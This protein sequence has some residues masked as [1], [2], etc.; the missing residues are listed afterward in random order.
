MV[1]QNENRKRIRLGLRLPKKFLI[2]SPCFPQ[3]KSEKQA[4]IDGDEKYLEIGVPKGRID[5][6][7]TL[8]FTTIAKL[9]EVEK[10]CKLHQE[11]MGWCKKNKLEIVTMTM[12]EVGGW[13]GK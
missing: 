12:E 13:L 6:L 11:L 1:S 10:P 2:F 9:K 5:P 4:H 8:G 7:K 3:M